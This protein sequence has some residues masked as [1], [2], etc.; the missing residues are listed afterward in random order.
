MIAIFH[1]QFGT[2]RDSIQYG[3]DKRSLH[4]STSPISKNPKL[5]GIMF[6][7]AVLY[8]LTSLDFLALLDVLTLLD[9]SSLRGLLGNWCNT[10]KT[11]C[12]YT[13][14]MWNFQISTFDSQLI[15]WFKLHFSILALFLMSYFKCPISNIKLMET[16]KAMHDS[17]FSFPVWHL[18]R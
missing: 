5:K 9:F 6:R 17:Y 18:E 7:P 12:L 10:V 15:S 14:L 16:Y 8:F 3:L 11:C 13:S 1:S 4:G 2:W